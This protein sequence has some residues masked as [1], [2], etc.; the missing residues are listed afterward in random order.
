MAYTSA[1]VQQNRMRRADYTASP[2]L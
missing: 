2:K 1:R